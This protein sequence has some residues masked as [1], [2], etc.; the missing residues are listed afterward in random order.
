MERYPRAL[1]RIH[2]AVA[3][4]V[5]AQLAVALV[6][7]QLRSLEFGQ[8]VLALHR[9]TGLIVLI[10]LLVRLAIGRRHVV[11]KEPVA[12]LPRWQTRAA[13]G[14]HRLF[15]LL[16]IV[17]PLIGLFASW[18]RGDSVGV[19]GI[20]TVPSPFE[21][22]DTVRDNLLTAHIVGASLLL[23]LVVVHI[24]AI[25]FNR[26]V[27]G[28]SVIERMLPAAPPETLINRTPVAAQMALAF[29]S[30]IAV[31]LFTGMYAISKYRQVTQLTAAFQA[32][33]LAA[34][35]SARAAQV[36]WKE[37]LG[38]ASAA[39]TVTPDDHL[40]DLAGSAKSNLDDAAAHTKPG[41]LREALGA[42][43]GKVAAAT[44]ATAWQLAD[45]RGI[46]GQ[47]QDI[48]DSQ[49][50]NV[51]QERTENDEQAARGHDLIVVAMV[52]TM[53]I[54]IFIAVLLSRSINGSLKRMSILV[55]AV[56]AGESDG[57][58]EVIGR[59]EF[60][61][62]MRAMLE[63]RAAVEQRGREMLEMRAA[64]AQRDADS[65]AQ[66]HAFE[67]ERVRRAE[68]LQARDAATERKD[69]VERQ[70]QRARLTAEF[71]T[72]VAGIVEA[73][74]DT[75][76]D[77]KVTA[78]NMAASAGNTTTCNREASDM[79]RLTSD[80]AASIAPAAAQLSAAANGVRAHAEHSRTQSLRVV[81][82]AAEAKTQIESLVGAA[83]QIGTI[84]DEIN[85][86]ARHT[87]L[88]AI[89]AR[90][91]AALA[92][93]AGRGFAVVATEVKD[94]ATKTRSA[95]DGIG[96]QI[97]QVTMVA[98]RS[99]E[100]LQRVLTRIESLESAAS[101]IC[102]SADA[103]CASTSDIA[104]R[105]SEISASTQSVAENIDAAQG[106]ASAT[107]S[108]AAVVV[109]AADLLEERAL[110]LQDQVANFVLQ[111]QHGNAP[112]ASSAAA[113]RGRDTAA[114]DQSEPLTRAG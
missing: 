32:G 109:R 15:L 11:P 74:A 103:Q 36:A 27:R 105:M 50:A 79:A 37:L 16:L 102:N 69:R 58:L 31:S 104:E 1:Q 77:L 98:T 83:R 52:P 106:T 24:G 55:H 110:Q 49:A 64:V 72:Q 48:V 33:D 111:I 92:G 10:L 66:T 61:A 88:L 59:G 96:R 71:E 25:A 13:T 81:E 67:A 28:V 99:G 42:L 7:T 4:L 76:R 65:A 14:V 112:P 54:G 18:A 91:Q 85:G 51:F 90:I 107:E 100:F 47:L 62:L 57:A 23:S 2:W 46:D 87:S 84:A 114:R 113:A 5:M 41:D 6:L 63:M 82:E 78:D 97:E 56:A 86:I 39:P 94:L 30:L 53:V 35:D 95:V 17:Q 75:V 19:L 73:V 20:L 3:L 22:S 60:S 26:L 89:N 44:P 45:L 12:G 21:I 8:W 101:G 34:A 40:R 38:L 93:E 9:Q 68:E 29:G 43:T 80:R 108:M 70:Q